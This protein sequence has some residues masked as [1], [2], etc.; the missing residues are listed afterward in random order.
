MKRNT[1]KRQ[2]TPVAKKN[3]GAVW[4]ENNRERWNTYQREYARKRAAEKRANA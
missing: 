4:V 3:S 2:N 1:A